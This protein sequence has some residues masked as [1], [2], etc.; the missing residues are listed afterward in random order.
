MWPHLIVD[1]SVR[2]MDFS[3]VG[4]EIHHILDSSFATYLL[5]RFYTTVLLGSNRA[6][7]K[8]QMMP[9]SFGTFFPNIKR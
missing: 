1:A 8:F 4:M 7:R 2:F 5:L 9:E 3:V 6:S